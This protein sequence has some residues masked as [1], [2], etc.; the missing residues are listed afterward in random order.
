MLEGDALGPPLAVHSCRAAPAEVRYARELGNLPP[1]IPSE[2]AA[3]VSAYQRLDQATACAYGWV[4]LLSEA[5]VLPRWLT[6]NRTEQQRKQ[7]ASS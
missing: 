1:I 5:E 6:L 7:V 4:W 3:L 2:A